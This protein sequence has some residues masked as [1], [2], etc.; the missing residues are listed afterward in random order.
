VARWVWERYDAD[1]PPLLREARIAAQREREKVRQRAREAARERSRM[2]RDEYTAPAR[3]RRSAATEMHRAGLSLR[4]IATALRCSL[5]EIQRVLIAGV[6]GSPGLS[7]FKGAPASSS[8][9]LD[10]PTSPIGSPVP[11]PRD[12]LTPQFSGSRAVVSAAGDDD[13]RGTEN[14]RRL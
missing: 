14:Q 11:R 12:V 10:V 1:V 8:A 5:A 6:P 13:E 2:S 3:Q 9:I 4:A 7:D